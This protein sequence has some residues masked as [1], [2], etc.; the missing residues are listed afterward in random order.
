MKNVTYKCDKCEKDITEHGVI[1]HLSI[2]NLND[3]E[4]SENDKII[5][6]EL[7]VECK[8]KIIA[9]IKIKE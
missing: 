2:H 7:C 6:Y 4:I 9:C 8:K 3:G 1:L 5:K